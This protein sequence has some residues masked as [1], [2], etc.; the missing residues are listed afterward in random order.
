MTGTAA[1]AGP[2][3]T[4]ASPGRCTRPGTALPGRCASTASGAAT[5]RCDLQRARPGRDRAGS[6]ADHTRPQDRPAAHH[7]GDPRGAGPAAVAGRPVRRR[8]VGAQR[9]RR[10][11][12]QAAPRPGPARLHPPA[13]PARPGRAHPAALH[14]YRPGHA[15]LLP[16][17]Q[18]L[19][20]R[21]VH[22]RGGPAI[23]SSNSSHSA[24]PAPTAPVKRAGHDTPGPETRAQA[25]AHDTGPPATLRTLR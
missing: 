19:P 24:K 23:R 22:H 3:I 10:R 11:A 12:G 6:S 13:A 16:G 1:S 8:A 2:A 7:P 25:A 17:E 15:A 21:G 9:A 5:G 18:G 20:G 14:S 4:L